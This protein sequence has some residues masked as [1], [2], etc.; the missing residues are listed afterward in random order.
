MNVRFVTVDDPEWNEAFARLPRNRRDV[1]Y[2]PAYARLCQQTT[3]RDHRVLCALADTPWGPILYPFVV[4]ALSKVT[5]LSTIEHSDMVGLYGRNGIACYQ[6]MPAEQI[7]AFHACIARFASDHDVVCSFDRFHPVL[8][9]Q[10]QTAEDVRLVEVGRFTVVS[11][12]GDIDVI[13]RSYRHSL[14]KDIKKAERSGVS[15]FTETGKEHLDDFLSIYLHTMD[16]RSAGSSYLF[17]IDYFKALTRFMTDQILFIYAM[18]DGNVVS[19]ELVLLYGDYSHSFLGGTRHSALSF[20]CNQLLKRNLIR[21]LKR[22]GCRYFLLGGGLSAG[23]GIE[24]YK[25]AFAPNAQFPSYVG[26]RVF[27][28]NALMQVKR[29]MLEAGSAVDDSRIQFYDVAE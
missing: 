29:T 12:D 1:F 28:Q 26:G 8:G 15:T 6:E 11:L 24:R 18:H 4:R 27:D 25:T 23:D 19:C 13:E 2:G 20:G 3:C 21:E 7:Q 9:N 16:R 5:R 10:Q 17:D 14:R 22:G